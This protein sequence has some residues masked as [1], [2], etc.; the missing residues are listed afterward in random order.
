MLKH[1]EG[2][3]GNPFGGGS[4]GNPFGGDYPGGGGDVYGDILR[5]F[6]SSQG[7]GGVR[8]LSTKRG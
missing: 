4:G 3:G 5:S 1:G 7:G 8:R 6:M 2:R